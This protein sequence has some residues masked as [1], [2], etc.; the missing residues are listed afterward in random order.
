MS[1]FGGFRPL[2]TVPYGSAR[3]SEKEEAPET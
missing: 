3:L 1:A 2:R